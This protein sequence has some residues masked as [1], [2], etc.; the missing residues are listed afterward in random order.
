MINSLLLKVKLCIQK[1]LLSVGKVICDN[2]SE[3]LPWRDNCCMHE[4]KLHE[5]DLDKSLKWIET[6]AVTQRA[7]IAL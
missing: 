5:R 4:R 3:N 7:N 6:E 2:G 1:N